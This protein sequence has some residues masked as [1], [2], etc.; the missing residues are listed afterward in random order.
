MNRFYFFA[1]VVLALN[2]LAISNSNEV[3]VLEE[4]LQILRSENF[5]LQL[6]SEML[7]GKGYIPGTLCENIL[8]KE[9]RG[10]VVRIG[11]CE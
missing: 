4:E 10:Y 1:I 2:T 8:Y 6:D 3:A 9:S 7:Y 11:E 5:V